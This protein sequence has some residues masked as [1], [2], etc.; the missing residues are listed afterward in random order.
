MATDASVPVWRWPMSQL[1]MWGH[2]LAALELRLVIWVGNGSVAISQLSVAISQLASYRRIQFTVLF[3]TG[4]IFK[5]VGNL[6]WVPF[7]NKCGR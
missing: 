1:E 6:G 4:V 7:L 5:K 2:W 3:C